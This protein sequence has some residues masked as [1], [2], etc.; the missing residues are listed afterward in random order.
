MDEKIVK[1]QTT[2]I[3][4]KMKSISMILLMML[5]AMTSVIDSQIKLSDIASQN[6]GARAMACSGD[7]CLNEAMPNPNGYDNATWPNGEWMEIT[8]VGNQSIDIRNYELQNKAN[9]RLVFDSNSIVGYNQNNA[10]TYT[11]SPGDYMVIARNGF[12]NFYLA[13]S[14]DY[15][16]LLDP[17]GNAVDQASWNTS[18]SG[19]SLERSTPPSSDWQATSTPTPGQSNSIFEDML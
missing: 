18:S 1:E 11:I 4:S 13:N 3:V 9:K 5:M 8:N 15:I 19:V 2:N 10:S 14:F 7:I 16:N 12:S 6:T 17:S